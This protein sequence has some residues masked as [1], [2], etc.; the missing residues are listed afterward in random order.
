MSNPGTSV[1]TKGARILETATVSGTM[2][3]GK[4]MLS[5]YL[6]DN[7]L[8]E[9]AMPLFNMAVGKAMEKYNKPVVQEVLDLELKENQPATG[10]GLAWESAKEYEIRGVTKGLG[11]AGV[12][13][14]TGK[15]LTIAGSQFLIPVVSGVIKESLSSF[16]PEEDQALVAIAA[17]FAVAGAY[18]TGSEVA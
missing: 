11:Q 9:M 16:V 17:N 10:L 13:F 8:P 7:W 15:F 6:K 2:L 12:D 14:L 18:F 3:Y 4:E 1:E 5:N